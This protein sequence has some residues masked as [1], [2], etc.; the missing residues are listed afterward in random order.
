MIE[1]PFSVGVSLLQWRWRVGRVGGG[2]NDGGERERNMG[3]NHRVSTS[4]KRPLISLFLTQEGGLQLNVCP[5]SLISE[6]HPFV[7]SNAPQYNTNTRA[8]LMQNTPH[9]NFISLIVGSGGFFL[10]DERASEDK[11]HIFG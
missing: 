9:R 10:M 7:H 1:A 11:N 4:H 2:M 3:L 8:E 5:R 6:I